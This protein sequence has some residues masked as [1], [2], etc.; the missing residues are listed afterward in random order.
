MIGPG[1]SEKVLQGQ[2][3]E[4]MTPTVCLEMEEGLERRVRLLGSNGTYSNSFLVS[5][6]FSRSNHPPK[7]LPSLEQKTSQKF[8][9]K[10]PLSA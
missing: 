3:R 5:R 4:Q 8:A 10:A 1:N 7:R 6:D 9:K 2:I